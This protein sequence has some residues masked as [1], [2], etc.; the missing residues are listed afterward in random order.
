MSTTLALIMMVGIDAA[1]FVGAGRLQAKYDEKK[2]SGVMPFSV[3]V[4][5]ILCAATAHLFVTFLLA[6]SVN[7]AGPGGRALVYSSSLIFGFAPSVRL[8]LMLI[9]SSA[10]TWVDQL[11]G[12]GT[13]RSQETDFSKA[14]ALHM[15]G[16][17][18]GA[19]EQFRTY[20][21]EDTKNP[22][23]LFEAE[24][25][26]TKSGRHEKSVE[27]LREILTHF[28]DNDLVWAR[29]A[30]RIADIH[31]HN[32]NDPKMTNHLLTEIVDRVPESDFGRLARRRL[33]RTLE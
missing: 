10:D 1:I 11:F 22:R 2:S 14:K 16:D 19:I 32:L 4:A 31:E 8:A 18:E 17:I 15:R 12:M 6:A 5:V 13:A 25:M 20:F 33:N 29:A 23:P 24:F 9:Q 30:Y 26:L 27:I 21:W 28:Q 7:F 3:L